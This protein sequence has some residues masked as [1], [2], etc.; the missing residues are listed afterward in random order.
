MVGAGCIYIGGSISVA[1]EE[2]TARWGAHTWDTQGPLLN[3]ESNAINE[4]N[5][6]ILRVPTTQ[7]ANMSVELEIRRTHG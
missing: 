4:R 3:R 1:R 7:L 6:S 5:N 2:D